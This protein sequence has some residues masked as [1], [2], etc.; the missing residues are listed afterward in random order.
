LLDKFINYEPAELN[1]SALEVQRFQMDWK[2]DNT[3]QG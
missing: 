3:I 2:F 1:D